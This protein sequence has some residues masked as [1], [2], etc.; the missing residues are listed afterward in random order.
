MRLRIADVLERLVAEG[1]APRESIERARA[2]LA[3]AVDAAPPWLAR[4]IAGFGAWVATACL[5]GFLVVTKIVSEEISA[6]IVGAVLVAGALYL[7]RTADAEEEF[8]RQLAFAGSLA[9]QVLVIVGVSGETKSAALAGLVALVMSGVLIPLVPDQ[10]HRFMSGLIGS[11]GALAAMA[12]LRLAWTLGD[13]G[14]LGIVAIRGTDLAALAIVA[15]AAY[16]WRIGIRGRSREHAEMLEPVGYGTIAALLAVLLFTSFFAVA[17][18][19]VR[20]PQSTRVN[21]WQL[22]PA[23]TAGITAALITLELAIFAEQ[24]ATTGR[25]PVVVAVAA[26]LLLGLLTLSTPGIMAAV[27]V[28]TLGFDRRDKILIGI[29]V[30]FLVKFASVYYYSLRMTLLEKSIVLAAS[31]L[32]LLAARAYLELRHRPSE[33]DA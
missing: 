16:I 14:P 8:K 1:L 25:E 15:L 32:L 12:D 26:T 33:A 2:A 31:G 9:G 20:G 3:G 22:G 17:D 18:D 19:L 7:R 13:G 6:M 29:A 5:I 23:T 27:A 28:L 21:A 10:A 24:R 30:V 11:V 4:L